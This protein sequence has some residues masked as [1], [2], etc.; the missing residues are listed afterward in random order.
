MDGVST[1]TVDRT[2]ER[3]LRRMGLAASA[4]R[5]S[6]FWSRR[7]FRV[8]GIPDDAELVNL[9]YDPLSDE[10]QFLLRSSEF[11]IVELGKTVPAI[12][13]VIE[14]RVEEPDELSIPLNTP[15]GQHLLGA[16][17][18]IAEEAFEERDS[19]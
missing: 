9:C 2:L 17:D 11:S 1:E 6:L 8:C 7:W 3:R 14:T 18:L 4:I 5:C 19:R 16:R 10:W 15:E 13:C 12:D